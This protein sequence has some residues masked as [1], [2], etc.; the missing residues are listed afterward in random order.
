M[1]I[2]PKLAVSP[3]NS[4]PGN[5]KETPVSRALFSCLITTLLWAASPVSQAIPLIPSQAP[6]AVL[7]LSSNQW[8]ESA[9]LMEAV[10]L[11]KRGE[12]QQKPSWR[13]S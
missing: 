5:F 7:G 10:E 1:G 9:I 11:L 13:N 2:P 3:A 12:Q 6:Q 8:K 4:S